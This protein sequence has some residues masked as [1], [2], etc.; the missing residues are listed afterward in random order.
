MFILFE[1]D[2]GLVHPEGQLRHMRR[3][4]EPDAT[5]IDRVFHQMERHLDRFTTTVPMA[6]IEDL[7]VDYQR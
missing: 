7:L 6:E 1:P 4:R 5:E 2:V 3:D